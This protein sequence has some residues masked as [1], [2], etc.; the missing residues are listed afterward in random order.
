VPTL[1]T[2]LLVEDEPAIRQL[3]ATV[4]VREGYRVIEARNGRE[5]LDLFD[6]SV[7]LLLT[8]MRLPHISGQQVINELKERRRTLKVLS[9]SGYALNAP[10]RP[11]EAFLAKPFSQAELLKQIRLVLDGA[12]GE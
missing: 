7:D 6:E 12:P 3:I 9:I 11:R 10:T 8:D 1:E 2:I 4:L 5:A